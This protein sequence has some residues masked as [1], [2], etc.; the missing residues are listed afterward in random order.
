VKAAARMMALRMRT[1]LR[2]GRRSAGTMAP[3][4]SGRG[5]GKL[6]GTLEFVLRISGDFEEASQEASTRISSW[7]I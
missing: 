6:E 2:G 7:H 5:G 3:T 4:F 1:L